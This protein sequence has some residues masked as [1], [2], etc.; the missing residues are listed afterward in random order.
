MKAAQSGA[1]RIGVFGGAFDPPHVAHVALVKAALA[2]LQLDQL[3]VV[4]TGGAWHKARALTPAPQRLAM[5]QLA[6]S[7]LP[8]V[9]VDACEIERGGPSYTIDTLREFKALWPAAELFLILGEDQVRALPKWRAGQE[10]ARLAII[11]VAAREDATG[12]TSKLGINNGLESRFRHLSMPALSVS[13]SD[14]RHRIA[15][16][17]GVADLVFEPVARYIAL[18]HLYQ[19]T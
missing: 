9:V 3:R 4:P 11:C 18:H 13:A 15:T 5:A 7:E 14:I 19:T 2:E 10:I 16:H 8:R 12:A 6:F 17:A 1:R